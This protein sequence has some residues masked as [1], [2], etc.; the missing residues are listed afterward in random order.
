MTHLVNLTSHSQT[1]SAT[2]LYVACLLLCTIW[3]F[4]QY[5]S[6]VI[7]RQ[8]LSAGCPTRRGLGTAK[9]RKN[10]CYRKRLLAH[11]YS[12]PATSLF[13]HHLS[14][15]V[16]ARTP[17]ARTRRFAGGETTVAGVKMS[18]SACCAVGYVDIQVR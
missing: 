18:V 14:P 15:L 1:S 8:F 7:S 3:V 13:S 16:L 5:G 9:R 6:L 2:C 12:L 4:F 10:N 17:A 11:C